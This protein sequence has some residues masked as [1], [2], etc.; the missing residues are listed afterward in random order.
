MSDGLPARHGT[1]GDEFDVVIVGAGFSG[2]YM[3]H[4]VRELGYSVRVL[5]TGSD[6]GGT[7]Y[8]NRYPGARCD[9]ESI[10]Y[11][12][13]FSE[14]LEQDWPLIERYP[15][16]PTMLNYLQHVADRFDLR[17]NI[18][19]NT[20]V[21][22]GSYDEHENRWLVRTNT[23]SE[24]SARFLITAVGCLSATN[25]PELPGQ[26]RFKGECHHTSE[27][28]HDGVD[29]S[30]RRVAVIG[31]GSTGIQLIPEVAKTAGQLTVFQRTPQFTLPARNHGLEASY[32]DEVKAN[33]RDLRKRC[34]ES[35]VGTPYTPGNRSALEM[36][37]DEL[38]EAYEEAWSQGGARFLGTFNDIMVSIDANQTAADFVRA[39]IDEIV[40]DPE[41]AEMLKPTSYPIGTKR[42]PIDSGYYETFNRENVKLVD[43]SKTPLVEFT[44]EGLRTTEAE[45]PVD[46]VIFATGFDALTG[47]LLRL[48]LVG[49]DGVELRDKWSE[50]PRTYLGLATTGFPNLFT[51]TGPGSPSVLSNMPVSI[52]QHVEWI[53]DCLRFLD[54]CG[55]ETIE[56]VPEAEDAWT[57]HV[58]QVAA[59][60][61]Y[62]RAASW[63]MGANIA[64]KARTFLPYIG[65]VANYRKICDDVASSEYRGFRVP[66]RPTVTDVR[67]DSSVSRY[68]AGAKDEKVEAT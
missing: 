41:V 65:G 11:S 38:H 21:V 3:L 9:S 54:R 42:I 8:W 58:S 23:A 5:E 61:L 17:K 31:T 47:P 52:E 67:F 1:S 15:A 32:V 12:Y 33:Y 35:S 19:F 22:S 68:G 51:I 49:R 50:G 6:V 64:G 55:A 16:Q 14:E 34:R 24:L 39:K 30:G 57:E 43:L 56:A 29:Y 13:S 2:L 26:D 59:K 27:W 25:K 48:N 10:Y 45:F 36:R 28:P 7:W 60:T 66:G 20:R 63:Y 44:E 62:P 4:C 46:I 37:S 18:V 40:S 53:R